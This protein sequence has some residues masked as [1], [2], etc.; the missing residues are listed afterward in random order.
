MPTSASPPTR[1][2]FDYANLDAE[3]TQ[4]VQQQ[5]GEIR[6]LMKRTAQNII[7][8]GQKLIEVKDKLGHGRFGDWLNSEFDWDER[9]ARRFMTVADRFSNKSDNL[10]DI[11]FA[12]SALYILAAPSTP[13]AA[14]EEAISRAKAG[15]PI[16]YTMAKEI[17]QKYTAQPSEAKLEQINLPAEPISQPESILN[18]HTQSSSKLEIVSIRP[19]KTASVLEESGKAILPQE[20]Q[21]LRD[22][23]SFQV[24]TAPELPGLWWLLGGR[25]L[26]YCG[27]PNSPQ[28]LTRVAQE[29]EKLG[30]L[31][32][33][34]PTSNWL[35]TIGARARI[36]IEDLPQSKDLRLFE[37]TLESILLLY[38]RLDDLVVTCFLPSTEI[39]S[40]INRLERRG[41]F[42]EP[43]SKRVNAVLLDWKRAGLKAE[44]LS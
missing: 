29:A 37:D 21:A 33:F 42:V 39:L 9:T 3:T 16:T 35:S 41:I 25:H 34:P 43:D 8:V 15:E 23:Q 22:L 6:T 36:I 19:K 14:R 26:L 13:K 11:N 5:T 10:S 18:S 12:P 38:S 17:K 31:L 4:F 7:E 27:N 32:A 28:F 40:I 20:V 30:L 24:N 44:R 2:G 1:I